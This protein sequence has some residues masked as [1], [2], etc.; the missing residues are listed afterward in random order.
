MSELEGLKLLRRI[1]EGV[2]GK[3][4]EAFFRQIVRDLSR[5]LNAHSAFTSRLMPER[6]ASMLAFW[7]GEQYEKCLEYSLAGTPCEYVYAGQITAYARD[8]G[9]VFPVDREWFEQLGV[10]SYLG[11]PVKGES[12]EVCGHLAV[13]DTRE[14]DW[15]DADVDVLRL[16][17]LRSAAEIERTRYQREL[18]EANSSLRLLNEKLQQ[19][20]VR[21]EQIE[22]ELGEAKNAA[23]S[24]SRAKSVF[25]SQMSHELR[26]PLNGILGYAQLLGQS[27]E[28]PQSHI[29]GL[30][31]I[32]RSGQHLLT[33]IND[34]L[35]LAKIEAGR[36]EIRR[37]RVDLREL[38]QHVTD[39]IRPRAEQ[40]RLTF[41]FEADGRSLKC[42]FADARAVRQMLLNLLG[43]AVKFT[44]PGGRVALSVDSASAADRSRTFRFTVED[45]GI[46][47]EESEIPSLF[48]PFHRFV[49]PGSTVEGTGLGL[50]ITARLVEAMD[51]RIH[52]SSRPGAG[53]RFVVELP[54]DTIEDRAAQSAIAPDIEGYEGERRR[55]LV[56]DDQDDN[57]A[58]VATLLESIGFEVQCVR[59]GAQALEQIECAAPDLVI[60]D[61]VMPTMDGM[62][63][64]KKL[65]GQ[66]RTCGIPV[67]AL[68]ASAG[69]H[70]RNE[71]LSAGCSA[72]VA[73]P[74]Q[75]TALLD[76]IARLLT[77]QWRVRPSPTPAVAETAESKDGSFQLDEALADELQHLAMLGDIR[78]LVARADEALGTNPAA[79]AFCR[80]FRSLA[81]RYDTRG[82]R[83]VI[84][85]HR[86]ASAERP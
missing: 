35:D 24:A 59:N 38:L 7:V 77:L 64:V 16:F 72:F 10:V 80:E 3:T 79:H 61:L 29:E 42:V 23:E 17:S 82:I 63:L 84:G 18:E 15:R 19:E 78:E 45:T 44:E 57:R 9:K 8:V 65:R 4:G 33:L 71:A 49:R 81:G 55:V 43:N 34:L 56:A 53:S 1:E 67:I 41:S 73:K 5:A 11:I 68:S 21:R 12:G 25:I 26:T 60:T 76:E 70:T 27:R 86:G 13:M 22:L 40:A 62:T 83:R 47:I 20:I 6:R 14:R 31:V 66:P 75:L 50:A 39:L 74:F 85:A 58:V 54:L 36:L 51:G 28:L 2:A 52:V 32:E 30:S 69:E 46:G 37:E 48:E